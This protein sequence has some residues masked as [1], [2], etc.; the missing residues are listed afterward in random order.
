MAQYGWKWPNMAGNGPKWKKVTKMAENG[1]NDWKW[2]NMT[3]NDPKWA[4]VTKM[5]GNGQ[6]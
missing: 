5:A 6:K 4:K 3:G 2:P 1:P